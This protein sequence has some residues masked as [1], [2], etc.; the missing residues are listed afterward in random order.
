MTRREA[1][2][3]AALVDEAVGPGGDLSPVSETDAVA[4]FEA[5][6][7]ASP[8]PNRV[9]LR[10]LVLVRPAQVGPLRELLGRL[11][12]CCYYGDAGVMRRLGYD[13]DAVVA[14]AA[15]LRTLEGRP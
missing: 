2:R 15:E 14:R 4:A 8:R 5:W 11:A 10:A 12:A 1:A 6:L 7:R 3:F 13:A 9:A